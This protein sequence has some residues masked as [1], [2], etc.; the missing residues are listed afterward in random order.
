MT[1]KRNGN[2]TPA[3]NRSKIPR[4]LV[5]QTPGSAVP[6]NAAQVTDPTSMLSL[7]NPPNNSP[8]S[9]SINNILFPPGNKPNNNSGN[10]SG[11][12]GNGLNSN[13]SSSNSTP[14]VNWGSIPPVNGNNTAPHQSEPASLP[15]FNGLRPY[16]ASSTLPSNKYSA[17]SLNDLMKED[18][19]IRN[20]YIV[21]QLLK[22]V[23][24]SSSSTNN[25]QAK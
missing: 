3:N 12:S 9:N 23:S 14:N 1:N 22:I 4:I 20:K 16:L 24:G 15:R 21:L 17:V 10:S 2:T 18:V 5:T 6:N 25:D 11:S 7:I 13:N 19:R 8:N